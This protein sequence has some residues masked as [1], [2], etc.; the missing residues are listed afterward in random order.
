MLQMLISRPARSRPRFLGSWMPLSL[1]L[2]APPAHPAQV[3]QLPATPPTAQTAPIAA[4]PAASKPSS[5][6]H[7]AQVTFANGVLDV[8][9][10][11][12]SLN[13][14]LRDIA[15]ETGMKITGGVREER[16][17]GHYGP[18]TPDVILA[19]LIDSNST[20]MILR[21][22]IGDAPKELILTPRAGGPTPPNP[23]AQNFN[24][25]DDGRDDQDN[26]LPPQM[27]TPQQRMGSQPF[28]RPAPPQNQYTPPPTQ[29]PAPAAPG[30]VVPAN[31]VNGDP[32]NVSPTASTLPTTNSVSLDSVPTP[33]TTPPVSGIVDAPNP[34]DPATVNPAT[35]ADPN[36][37]NGVKTPEQIYQQLQQLQRQHDQQTKPQ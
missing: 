33:S 12:S 20:N 36:S 7:R 11:N 4:A 37:P 23:N 5:T 3:S 19:T 16:V 15:H 24:G 18:A 32:N 31:N 8:R 35:T 9:A 29:N 17:F 10:D 30:V 2:L 34:P 21:D 1:L 28:G 13:Q 25:D 27:Q 26:H 22:S 6:T 14:I